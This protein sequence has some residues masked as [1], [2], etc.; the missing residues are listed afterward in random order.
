MGMTQKR[1]SEGAKQGVRTGRMLL[2]GKRPPGVATAV[3]LAQQTDCGTHPQPLR[4]PPARGKHQDGA[5]RRLSEG[6]EGSPEAAVAD[7]LGRAAS[8]SQ[9]CLV[10]AYVDG[11]NGQIQVAFVPPEA[12]SLNP[13]EYLR[14]WLKHPGL[15]GVGPNDLSELHIVVRNKLR[16]VQKRPSIIATCWMQ[17]TLW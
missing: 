15:A 14:A 10:R 3:G 7:H 4:V 11:L 2:A 9:S 1:L 12:P 6:L 17:A 5:G 16:S 8:P 13:V